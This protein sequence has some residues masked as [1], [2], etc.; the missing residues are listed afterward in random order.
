V[1]RLYLAER[2]GRVEII[3]RQLLGVLFH[4]SRDPDGERIITYHGPRGIYGRL[5]DKVT[6]RWPEEA[7]SA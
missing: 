4:Q 6:E 7:L 2:D 1:W 3:E 5:I